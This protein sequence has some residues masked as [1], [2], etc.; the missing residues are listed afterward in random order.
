MPPRAWP[1]SRRSA[2]QSFLSCPGRYKAQKGLTARCWRRSVGLARIQG[3]AQAVAYVVDRQHRQEDQQARENGPV[4]RQVEEVLRVVQ[5]P[6]P[7]RHVGRETEP[8]ERE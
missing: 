4:R 3:V 2:R 7:R 5:Q 8:E 6:T 1:R